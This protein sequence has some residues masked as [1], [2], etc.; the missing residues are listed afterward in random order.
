[1][2]IYF[3]CIRRH[4]LWVS[5]YANGENNDVS[6]DSSIRWWLEIFSSHQKCKGMI[7][8]SKNLSQA[9]ANLNVLPSK[10]ITANTDKENADRRTIIF[11][12]FIRHFCFFVLLNRYSI[13]KWT[14]SIQWWVLI[15]EL[16]QVNP[17]H[18]NNSNFSER[19]ELVVVLYIRA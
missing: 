13:H 3:W 8:P 11:K 15:L 19:F 12:V 5:S 14:E 2:N 4:L 17:N 18:L 7:A 6:K 16:R 9:I 10:L 1:M